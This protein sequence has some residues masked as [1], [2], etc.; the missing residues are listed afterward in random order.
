MAAGMA[1]ITDK[2]AGSATT[3][4]LILCTKLVFGIFEPRY[5]AMDM[6]L[7]IIVTK[8]GG[9]VK[10]WLQKRRDSYIIGYRSLRRR[11]GPW[12]KGYVL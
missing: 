5:L 10:F 6:F 1:Y 8:Y 11:G 3:A 2:A 9:F 7:P 12:G 4:H